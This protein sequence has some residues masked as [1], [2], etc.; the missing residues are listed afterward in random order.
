MNDNHFRITTNP[1]K[2]EKMRKQCNWDYSHEINRFY[3]LGLHT[4]NH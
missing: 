2:A 1:E 4:N 3:F